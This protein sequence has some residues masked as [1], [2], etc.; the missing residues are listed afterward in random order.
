MRF[1]AFPLALILGVSTYES[2]AAAKS[3]SS[4]I[5]VSTGRS[6]SGRHRKARRRSKRH[7]PKPAGHAVFDLRSEV[8]PKPSGEVV[9]YDLARHETVNVNI[10]LPDGSYAPQAVEEVSHLLR[11]KRTDAEKPIEPRLMAILSHIHDKYERRIEVVSGYRN[12]Q[13]QTSF[14]FQGAAIDIRVPG[15]SPTKLRRFVHSLDTGGMGI[16]LYPRSRFVHVDIRPLPSYRWVDYSGSDPDDPGKKPPRD[17]KN[18]K[19]RS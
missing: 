6:S 1:L 4:V 3:E 15:I 13:R 18:K 14:H 2:E 17:F 19:L 9:L 16:G 10:Y 7:S 5:H 11:C 8:P 12:Q